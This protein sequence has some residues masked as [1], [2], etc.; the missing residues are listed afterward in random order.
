[1]HT[2]IYKAANK[3]DDI[4]FLIGAEARHVATVLRLSEGEIVR[5][6]DGQGDTE[7][8]EIA[9]IS[10]GRVECR[11]IKKVRNSGEASLSVTLAAG[12]SQASKFDSI[13]EKGTEV[14]VRNF[15]PLLTD[16]GKVKIDKP[17]T[18]T[19]KMNRW[20]RV[21]EA[22]VKQTGRSIIPHINEPIS[23]EEYLG[24][25][26]SQST[27]LFHPEGTQLNATDIFSN[28]RG[29]ALTIITG[30]ESGFSPNEIDMV[31]KKGC[32]VYSLG[33]RV[34]RAETAGIVFSALAIYLFE[35][36]KA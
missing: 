31:I 5:L 8:C 4:I 14:G 6:I 3:C 7:I 1:M 15:V 29:K 23:L 33:E 17:G 28:F 11:I 9:E 35:S 22:A 24:K 21:C 20:Q 13:I 10:T 18:L 32:A 16:K 19:R 2:F 30:P 25:T 26:D 12:L 27:I 36:V 34:L